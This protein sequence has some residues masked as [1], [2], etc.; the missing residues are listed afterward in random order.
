MSLRG[1]AKFDSNINSKLIFVE[2]NWNIFSST[3]K[4]KNNTF[5]LLSGN[6][7][8]HLL[9][10]LDWHAAAL[11]A[12]HLAALFLWDMSGHLASDGTA[13]RH[14]DGLADFW[15]NLAGDLDTS[16]LGDISADL[17]WHL[18]GDL[19]RHFGAFGTLDLLAVL[20]WF[21]PALLAGDCAAGRGLGSAIR[22]EGSSSGCTIGINL[23]G[24]L[25]SGCWSVIA[26]S[27]IDVLALPLGGWLTLVLPDVLALIFV[28]GV[29]DGLNLGGAALLDVGAKKTNK[30]T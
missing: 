13:F 27:L 16:Q 28:L 4:W 21:V 14:G 5:A 9:G 15:G 25:R 29:V 8:G 19:L 11:L 23:L 7:S 2:I 1:V 24:S 6:L 12:R 17:S 3:K 18:L 20:R 30:K 26:D 10:H 22:I